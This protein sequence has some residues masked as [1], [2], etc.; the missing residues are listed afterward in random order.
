METSTISTHLKITFNSADHQK[1]L[2]RTS[3][4]LDAG[5]GEHGASVQVGC[6]HLVGHHYGYAEFLGQPL[7]RPQE[8][9]QH[10]L[11]GG[12][13]AAPHVLIPAKAK[14]CKLAFKP[15]TRSPVT[16]IFVQHKVN[17]KPFLGG[18]NR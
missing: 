10:V 8:A 2:A 16:V 11:A 7:A 6:H 4:R 5:S 15:S 1:Q 18:S 3:Y 13:L 12:Q 9:A 14:P 17:E